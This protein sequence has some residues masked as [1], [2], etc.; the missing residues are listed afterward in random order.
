MNGANVRVLGAF[1]CACVMSP[2]SLTAQVV[3]WH[4]LPATSAVGTPRLAFDL[5]R[6]R[7][8]RVDGSGWDDLFA[9]WEWI[10]DTWS[11]RRTPTTPPPRADFALGYDPVRRRVVMFGG[12]PVFQYS[13]GNTLD[14]TWEYD[15]IDWRSV[16]TPVRPTPQIRAHLVF[17]HAQNKMMLLSGVAPTG[18]AGAWHYDGTTWTA[19]PQPP[20]QSYPVASDPL[21]RRVIAY[22]GWGP[23]DD[24]YEWDGTSWITRNP[25]PTPPSRFSGAMT[26]VPQRQRIVLHGGFDNPWPGDLWEW[27]GTSWSSIGPAPTRESHSLC[28]DPVRNVLFAVGGNTQN[29]GYSDETLRW[30]GANWT[31]SE[32]G[33]GWD[34]VRGAWFDG[35]R[36]GVV[37]TNVFPASML[38]WN[39]ARWERQPWPQ[40]MLDG[41]GAFDPVR[42]VAVM[43][44]SN[45]PGVVTQ[46][47]DG[48]TWGPQQPVT[49]PSV[50]R[51]VFDPGRGR[52]VASCGSAGLFEWNG[53]SWQSFAPGPGAPWNAVQDGRAVHDAARGELV[54][55]TWQAGSVFTARWNGSTWTVAQ[56][57]GGPPARRDHALC[58]DPGSQTVV[59]F[60]GSDP[61]SG[62][63]PTAGG[64]V[65]FADLW[66]WNGQSWSQAVFPSSPVPR[67]RSELVF[68]PVR[69]QLLLLGGRRAV[70]SIAAAPAGDVW[71]LD[72]R[73]RASVATLGPGCAGA[74]GAPRLV[75]G[76]PVPGA[77]V[78]PAEVHGAPPQAPCAFV[79]AFGAGSL[80]LGSGCTLYATGQD[81]TMFTYCSPTGFALVT[82]S[83]PLAL[84]G[85]AFV[86]QAVV[87]DA[88]SPLGVSLTEGV[89]LVV[90]R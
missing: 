7:M 38:L 28:H 87:L 14:D 5:H 76:A 65:Q 26:W 8:V 30:D 51:P 31:A 70:S 68:D 53:T 78:F 29:Q 58:Y 24:V 17:D 81:Q 12:R 37:A 41:R 77:S 15:G 75:F 44:G 55:V 63:H 60:G 23:L 46:E 45:L 49:L 83:I 86:G 36:Q 27:D 3:D 66:R 6:E 25:T 72:A 43:V 13:G 54:M 35:N 84:Q 20:F 9:T 67:E 80:P 89:Q 10:G 18:N 22:L 39:G 79:F 52:V 57:V 32:P 61:S 33:L 69:Q 19:L 1:V 85:F 4:R 74:S 16:V 71:T 47:W 50:A 40:P 73:T 62:T 59:M 34:D 64:Q 48:S 11:L 56:A 2:G 90:G 42:N 21:R 82:T 88:A